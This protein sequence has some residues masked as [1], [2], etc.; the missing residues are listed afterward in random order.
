MAGTMTGRP[1]DR[2]KGKKMDSHTKKSTTRSQFV[3]KSKGQ[4]LLIAYKMT[5]NIPKT[6]EECYNYITVLVKTG[7]P[8]AALYSAKVLQKRKHEVKRKTMSHY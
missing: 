5:N 6:E 7:S 4:K 1:E 8:M 3:Q 2:W